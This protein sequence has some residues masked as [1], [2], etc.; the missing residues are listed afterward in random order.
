MLKFSSAFWP[1][2]S[3]D[4]AHASMPSKVITAYPDSLFPSQRKLLPSVYNSQSGFS[5]GTTL[6]S[7]QLGYI[8]STVCKQSCSG[9]QWRETLQD[10][11]LKLV[12]RSMSS[13]SSTTTWY[14]SIQLVDSQC[15]PLF[16]PKLWLPYVVHLLP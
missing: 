1:D 15:S 8:S 2:V 12:L 4:K 11:Q 14:F 5:N 6:R 3:G 16:V 7:R 13:C 10:W 9:Q